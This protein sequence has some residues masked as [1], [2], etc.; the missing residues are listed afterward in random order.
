MFKIEKT[1]N[2][3]ATLHLFFVITDSGKRLKHMTQYKTHN[4][5]QKVYL[6]NGSVHRRSVSQ[7]NNFKRVRQRQSNTSNTPK[8]GRTNNTRTIQ[9]ILITGWVTRHR[10][11]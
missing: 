11:K 9:Y 7:A 4:S 10:W 1:F 6:Q 2:G 3:R 8:T 5:V